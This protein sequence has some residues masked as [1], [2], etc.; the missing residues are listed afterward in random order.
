MR[1]ILVAARELLLEVGSRGPSACARW[2]GGDFS[3]ASLYNYFG[4]R[5]E[6]IA[7]LFDE[8]FQRL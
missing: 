1:E 6:I 7:A 8:S 2:P 5:D 3:P 4:S